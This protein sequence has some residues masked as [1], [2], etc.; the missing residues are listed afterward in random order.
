[1]DLLFAGD[2][3]TRTRAGAVSIDRRL[4]RRADDRVVRHAD[5]VVRAEVGQRT[6]VDMGKGAGARRRHVGAAVDTEVGIALGDGH[7]HA[8]VALEFEIFRKERDVVVLRRDF[9]RRGVGLRV[10]DQVLL[11]SVGEVA[12]GRRLAV[13]SVGQVPAETL[14]KRGDE[15]HALQRI[16]TECCDRCFGADVG[17]D[18]ARHRECVLA[19]GGERG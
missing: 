2:E 14:V 7:H 17:K 11:D 10:I 18:V 5:V 13:H 19:D 12:E 4:G 6:T 1:M 9:A 16:E 8:F 15:L 3:A